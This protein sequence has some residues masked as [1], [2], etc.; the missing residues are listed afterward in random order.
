MWLP[1]D[2]TRALC[3]EDPPREIGHPWNP[4]SESGIPEVGVKVA[5]REIAERS[6]GQVA[7]EASTPKQQSTYTRRQRETAGDRRA[8]QSLVLSIADS[9]P[10]APRPARA[11]GAVPFADE[12]R[13]LER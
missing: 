9:Q 7:L 8:G 12:R 13:R 4:A 11:P 1:V 6:G 2:D 10:M 5:N 3:G